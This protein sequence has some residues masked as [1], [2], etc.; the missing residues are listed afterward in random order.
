MNA[1]EWGDAGA[2]DAVRAIA[3]W[4][5][6]HAAVS[7]AGTVHLHCTDTD[8]EWM[9]RPAERGIVVTSEHAKGDLAVRGPA[10]ALLGALRTGV[11]DGVEV[12]GD[13]SLFESLRA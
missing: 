10:T 5:D 7:I 13:P 6:E 11:L 2:H 9:I 12:F 1:N 4:L 3:E 8:G